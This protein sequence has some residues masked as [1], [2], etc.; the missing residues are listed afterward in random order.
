M[1]MYDII[2]KKRDRQELTKPEI[3]FF[4]EGYSKGDIPDYQASALLMAIYLNGLTNAERVYLTFA[5]ANSAL[6]INLSSIRKPGQYIVD[7]HS[8]GGVGDKVTLLVLPIV[9]ALGVD[10]CKMSG[11]GLGITGGTI[12]KL[13]SIVGYNVNIEVHEAIEQ[14]KDIGVCLI[15]QSKDIAIA[16]KKL[17]A[18]RDTTATVESMDLIASSIMSKKIASGA[19][20][21]L[22]DVTA[23]S[24]AFM[25]NIDEARRLAV[26]M[27][28]IGKQAK[29]ETKAV[30]TS[31]SEPLGRNV[32]NALEV[33]EVIAFL[34]SDE[35]TLY[36][37][38]NDLR[39]VV[40]EIAAQM[41]KM[42]GVG[43]DIED[44][45]S[46]ILECITSRAAYDKFVELIRAQGGHLYN[47]YMDWIGMSLDMPVLHDKA[48][49]L[50]EIHAQ[51]SGYVVSIDSAKIGAALVCIGGGRVKKEDEID[52]AVGFEFVKKVGE[53]VEE[54]ES[55]LKCIYN[56][57]KKF[58]EAFAY[59][60]DA[61][62]IEEID[63]SLA[64]SLRQKPH[65][66]DII[67]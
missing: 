26:T 6:R 25:K 58:E 23:G 62:L 63:P 31:M 24:G 59:I 61:I 66:L 46:D 45:K 42:A 41:M 37:E 10:V 49:Y 28:N 2:A 20:K 47:V 54:G 33:K 9:A 12:D 5:M 64:E 67:E 43:D 11:R 18:L 4:V 15:G 65:V 39:E 40:F 27:V 55:I 34:L 51:N 50:K 16:D 29:I 36:H 17:Y 52:H 14:V 22:L 44:N 48:K 21:V 8:T 7:K 3:D 53:R 13:E 19:D 1:R 30:I 38:M 32:G 35:T 60:G 57:K 56:D